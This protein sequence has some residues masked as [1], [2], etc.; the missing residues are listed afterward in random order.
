LLFSF[1]GLFV[2]FVENIFDH[3]DLSV[4]LLI[5]LREPNYI[6]LLFYIR[7]LVWCLADHNDKKNS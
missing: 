4:I 6:C 1:V 5:E 7:L 2:V 3:N